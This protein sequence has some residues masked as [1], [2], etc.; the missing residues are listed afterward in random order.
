MLSA[1]IVQKIFSV[2]TVELLVT[3][4]ELSEPL[5][6]FCGF[7]KSVP[8]PATF[9][10]FKD[11]IGPEELKKILD[12]LVELTEPYLKELDRPFFGL[13]SRPGHNRVRSSRKGE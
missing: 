13:P 10:R 9:S 5:K 4:L 8:D 2:P 3:F 6:D 12:R 7:T 11:K 1:L